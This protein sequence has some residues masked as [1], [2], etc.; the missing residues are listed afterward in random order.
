MS[1]SVSEFAHTSS[2]SLISPFFTLSF[3]DSFFVVSASTF[4]CRPRRPCRVHSIWSGP[5]LYVS[6]VCC[7]RVVCC[8]LC[9]ACVAASW[10][11]SSFPSQCLLR[12]FFFFFF[13]FFFPDT[14][15][16]GPIRCLSSLMSV[17]P[18]PGK[19]CSRSRNKYFVVVAL[20][21]ELYSFEL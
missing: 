21:V 4:L 12:M 19:P 13:F 20:L 7:A 9:G 8:V 2:R 17:M 5:R 15:S 18:R 3:I 1:V 10:R 16:P 6:Q 11:L 14:R